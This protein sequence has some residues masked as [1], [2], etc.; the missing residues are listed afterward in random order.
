M[1]L[2]RWIRG[3]ATKPIQLSVDAELTFAADDSERKRPR[4]SIRAYGGGPVNVAGYFRPI[5]IDLS[6]LRAKKSIPLLLEHDRERP[7]GMI[8]PRI[9]KH[10]VS[11]TGEITGEDEHANKVITHARNGF[12][13]SASVG[14]WPN[15]IEWVDAGKAAKANGKTLT[16]PVGI[17]RSGSLGE[18]SLVTIGA[19]ETAAANVAASAGKETAME[20]NEFVASL[21]ASADN[22]TPEQKDRLLALFEASAASGSQDKP[23]A[24]SASGAD[25]EAELAALR[26]RAAEEMARIAAVQAAAVGHPDIAA[27]AIGEG[28]DVDR[29]RLECRVKD[30]ESI[31]VNRG[32]GAADKPDV[33]AA[34]IRLGSAEPESQVAAS[35]GN[36]DELLSEA[37]KLRRMTL[38]GLVQRVCAMDG[39]ECPALSDSVDDWVRAA[40]G[41][42]TI[43]D[44]LSNVANK[45]L[46]DSFLAV[47]T[48]ARIIAKKLNANDFKTHTGVRLHGSAAMREVGEGGE[49]KQKRLE[50]T[51]FTFAVK[52]FGEM[53][54]LTRQQWIND[55]LNAFTAIPM[56]IGRGAANVIEQTLFELVIANTGDFFASG[57]SNYIEGAATTPSLDGYQAATEAMAQFTDKQ[58]VPINVRG[59]Y[60]LIPP[61]LWSKA[62]EMFISDMLIATGLASTSSKTRDPASN[63]FR[64]MYEPIMTPYLASK[65]KEWYLLADPT[66]PAA[67]F[68]IA[69][70]NGNETPVIE[71]VAP[72]PEYLG[73]VWRG[74]IDF[75]VC[76]IDPQG[77]VKSKGEA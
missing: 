63:V 56:M 52:T 60:V 28:W 66:G 73:R 7:I 25:L 58:G 43:A 47:P 38:R 10:E 20:F 53:I 22:L 55:D 59:R 36:N 13:W 45:M 39:R 26:K 8:A 11:A 16:G 74:Y 6:G 42:H 62:Q 18:I 46:Q 50:D 37:R 15:S 27:K 24:S 23:D 77:G 44:L 41:T 12:E 68:G 64:A 71:E 61:Q 4:V 76:Q 40:F 3:A 21:G 14:V 57:N 72:G 2:L 49:F 54:G 31:K 32:S 51:K 5:V 1:R 30:L 70:L 75:G 34:A 48:A 69:Y 9:T 29:T 17:I 65:P 35:Y 19:D 67:A 33:L